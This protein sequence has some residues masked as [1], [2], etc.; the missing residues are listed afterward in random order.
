MPNA[1]R[2]DLTRWPTGRSGDWP[3]P[4]PR[5]HSFQALGAGIPFG[6]PIL[7]GHH[8]ERRARADQRRLRD[9]FDAF[10]ELRDQAAAAQAGAESA[11]GHMRSRHNPALVARRIETLE[12]QRRRVQRGLDGSTRNHRNRDG[13]IWVV[14][15]HPPAVPVGVDLDNMQLFGCMFVR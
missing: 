9:H 4:T 11:E 15:T 2:S 6:Q 10:R 5:F 8:C 7:V 3:S 12:A 1:G 13:S 14:H